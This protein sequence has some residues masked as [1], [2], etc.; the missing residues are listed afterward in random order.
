MV[1]KGSVAGNSGVLMLEETCPL[2]A[3]P[4]ISKRQGL[5]ESGCT[6]CHLPLPAAVTTGSPLLSSGCRCKNALLLEGNVCAPLAAVL[7]QPT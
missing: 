4:T 6:L 3:P 5:L 1:A 2:D 7:D